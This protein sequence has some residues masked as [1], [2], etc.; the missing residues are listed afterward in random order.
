LL[1]DWISC[2]SYGCPLPYI[3]AGSL[4]EVN[5]DGVDIVLSAWDYPGF[6]QG[7][8]RLSAVRRQSA[9]GTWPNYAGL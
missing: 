2:V 9:P 1:I 5:N 4:K 6:Y 8:Y 3:L 7:G